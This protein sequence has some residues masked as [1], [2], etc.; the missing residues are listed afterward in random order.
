MQPRH[1]KKVFA[2]LEGNFTGGLDLPIQFSQLLTDG[3]ANFVEEIEEISGQ[4]V[5]EQGIED[6]M[7]KIKDKWDNTY[8]VVAQYRE[9]KHI[10]KEVEEAITQ[11]EDDSLQ[12]STMMGSKFVNEIKEEVQDW[13]TRLGY[14]SDVIDEWLTF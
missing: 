9:D 4:A 6:E 8:F 2:L 3:A 14:I 1:W 11:L 12:I 5:G 7:N 13:E 10:L